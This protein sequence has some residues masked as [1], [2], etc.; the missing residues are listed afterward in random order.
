M[1]KYVIK[2]K[3]LAA[4]VGLASKTVLAKPVL[5]ILENLLFNP[6][7]GGFLVTGSNGDQWATF[8]LVATLDEGEAFPFC[9]P[10][11]LVSGMASSIS[12][13]LDVTLMLEK[14]DQNVRVRIDYFTG[15]FDLIGYPSDEF[16][17][18]VEPDDQS[19]H[20]TVPA[21]FLLE[22]L[23]RAASFVGNDEL[24]P[25]MT[26]VLVNFT[27]DG[28][29]FIVGTDTQMLYRY[30]RDVEGVTDSD[31]HVILTKDTVN[32]LLGN[33]KGDSLVTITTNGNVLSVKMDGDDSFALTAR[34]IVGRYPNFN[35]VIPTNYTTYAVVDRKAFVGSLR[36]ISVT[37]SGA[38]QLMRIDFAS[39][40]KSSV[41]ISAEDLDFSTTGE[42][43]VEVIDSR[44]DGPMAVGLKLSK[45]LGIMRTLS[46]EQVRMEYLD[47]TRAVVVRPLDDDKCD[48]A[49]PDLAILM[50][51][52]LN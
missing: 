44:M 17:C 40:G 48:A 49:V 22:G 46:A 31:V 33:L 20:V 2:A 41:K 24:R 30:C 9:L 47:A 18:A 52:L 23:S 11:K 42:E 8:S 36:R 21:T 10:A 43:Y 29:L 1:T 15:F 3:E 12:P 35:S 7:G 16:P 38:S 37:T 28:K 34:A 14:N 25:I 5:P 51:M 39:N 45:L 27:K 26:G 13:D 19:V 32:M 50:P 4:V 6:V